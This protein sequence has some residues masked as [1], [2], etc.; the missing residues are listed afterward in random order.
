[1]NTFPRTLQGTAGSPQ[2]GFTL[3]ELLIT[4][5]IALF[6]LGG[7]LRI[8]QNVKTTYVNQQALAQLQDAQRFAMTVIADVV[9][10]AGYFP[11]PVTQTAAVAFRSPPHSPRPVSRSS[12]PTRAALRLTRCGSATAPRSMTP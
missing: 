8:V 9:Q 4:I 6:L 2:R 11:T 3:I 10:E 7:L 12:A 5:T 1:M